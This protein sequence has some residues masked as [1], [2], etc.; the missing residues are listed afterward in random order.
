VPRKVLRSWLAKFISDRL[1]FVA[2]KV[3]LVHRVIQASIPN[4]RANGT[5]NGRCFRG[6]STLSRWQERV[7]Y[8]IARAHPVLSA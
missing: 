4:P 7:S 3:R 6:D 2:D 8:T 5:T 1:W